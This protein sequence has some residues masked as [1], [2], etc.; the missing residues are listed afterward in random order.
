MF[1]QEYLPS[2][3]CTMASTSASD[4]DTFTLPRMKFSLPLLTNTEN[5]LKLTLLLLVAALDFR[6]ENRDKKLMTFLIP[7]VT[8]H[9][10][11]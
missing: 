9:R 4:T 8:P 3:V 6:P 11:C 5:L 7:G 2:P 1:T 10:H